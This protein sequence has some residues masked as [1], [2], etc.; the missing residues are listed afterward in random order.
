[1]T[2]EGTRIKADLGQWITNAMRY[3]AKYTNYRL[4][5]FTH[6]IAFSCPVLFLFTITIF[7][8]YIY[9]LLISWSPLLNFFQAF[10]YNQRIY[11]TLVKTKIFW[12]NLTF[13]YCG[14]ARQQLL[15]S[16]LFWKNLWKISELIFLASKL[17]IV[18][19]GSS[20]ISNLNLKCQ[21]SK[22]GPE[23]TL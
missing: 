2:E 7:R 3:K 21:N 5:N 4:T 10:P 16:I 17:Q 13:Y 19:L 23:L 20:S 9:T 6:Q 12:D 18:K 22:K 14:Q 15:W 11:S 1:M 8:L